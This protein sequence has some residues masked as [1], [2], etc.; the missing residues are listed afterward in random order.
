MNQTPHLR[1]PEFVLSDFY[2]S[3]CIFNPRSSFQK[4]GWVTTDILGSDFP[5][6][7][8]LPINGTLPVICSSAVCSSRSN[9]IFGA[10]G[11][12]DFAHTITYNNES[13][14][15]A[16]LAEC[17]QRN[18]SVIFMHQHP[19]AERPRELYWIDPDLLG[20]LNNKA[21]LSEFV[22]DQNLPERIV[23]PVSE[24]PDILNS[25]F[26]CPLVLKGA[27]NMPSG[28]GQAVAIVR[29]IQDLQLARTRLEIGEQIVAEEFLSIEENYCVNYATDGRQTFLLGCCEQITNEAGQY[30]GN[31][32]SLDC[33]PPREV[34]EV[35]FEIMQRAASRGYVGVAGFDIV[36]DRRGRILVLDLNFRLNGS[37]PALMW[38]N[39]LLSRSGQK[40]V[41]R[42]I[43]LKYQ[44]STDPDFSLLQELVDCGWLFP[45]MVYDPQASPYGF[46]EVRV[47]GILFGSSRYHVEHRLQKLHQKF[48]VADHQRTSKSRAA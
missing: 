39:R 28:G 36:R 26:S 22:P 41:G 31:W 35:G 7:V 12:P 38:Q 9:R 42:V 37:T 34:I 11:L 1:P 44:A 5:T 17:Y 23:L 19:E 13:D 27:A 48:G 14:F 25:G 20:Q 2:H 30:M 3:E 6:G 32:I 45:L 8:P 33:H 4:F 18:K 46:D 47:M 16:I 21:R 24:L 40:S 43:R 29:T 15:E 10:A